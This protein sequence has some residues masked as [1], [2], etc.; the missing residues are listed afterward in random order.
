MAIDA[1][2]DTAPAEPAP[3]QPMRVLACACGATFRAQSRP[4]AGV[5]GPWVAAHSQHDDGLTARAEETF[6]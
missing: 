1:L 5:L 4:D 2:A 3:G 6:Q